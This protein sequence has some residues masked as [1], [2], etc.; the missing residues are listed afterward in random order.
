MCHAPQAQNHRAVTSVRSAL[1]IPASSSP[2]GQPTRRQNSASMRASMGL[3]WK[4]SSRPTTRRLRPNT[5]PC[6]GTMTFSQ[7][8]G[9]ARATSPTSYR[10]TKNLTDDETATST[11]CS[12]VGGQ[13]WRQRASP[14]KSL[15]SN[16]T[17]ELVA[18]RAGTVLQP[19]AEMPA[20]LA[21]MAPLVSGTSVTNK[22]PRTSGRTGSR[23]TKVAH[24]V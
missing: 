11:P 21:L 17:K 23:S 15:A 24:G 1:Q 5:K 7:W 3:A 14:A 9:V 4:N 20:T 13:S 18:V 16:T 19:A 10:R 8:Q 22:L 12:S 2:T 6:S